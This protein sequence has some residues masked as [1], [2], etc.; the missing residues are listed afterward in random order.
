MDNYTLGE[1]RE[2]LMDNLNRKD[3][4]EVLEISSTGYGFESVSIETEKEPK[5]PKTPSDSSCGGL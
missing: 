1:N 3:E 2:N 4:K 5:T